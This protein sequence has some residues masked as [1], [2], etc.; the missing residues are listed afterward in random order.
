MHWAD[1]RIKDMAKAA[2]PVRLQAELMEAAALTGK[3]L[4]RSSAEQIEYWASIG[5]SVGNVLNPDSILAITA[6]LA[7]VKVEPVIASPVDPDQVFAALERDRK[8]GVLE[9]SVSQCKVRYQASGSHPGQLEQ[10]D[11]DGTITIGQFKEGVFM[12]FETT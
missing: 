11:T 10:I 12:P 5:R 2:S 6:G 7:R 3:R 8:S 4:H 1:K 9:Q